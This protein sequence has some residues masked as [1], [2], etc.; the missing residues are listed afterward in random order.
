MAAN[1]PGDTVEQFRAGLD[2]ATLAMIDALRAIVTTAYPGLEER[3]KWNAPSFAVAGD[4]RITLG[5]ER[6][7]GVRIVL[8]RGAAAKDVAGF[9]FEDVDG[10]AKWPAPDRGVATFRTLDAIE[11]VWEGLTALCRRWIEV[12]QD[13][14]D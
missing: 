5:I 2:A 10:I 7:G 3:I 8:H 13:A 12:T 1:Q 14:Q 4:D 11:S 6:K 9:A